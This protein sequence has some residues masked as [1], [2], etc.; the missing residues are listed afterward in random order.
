[1]TTHLIYIPINMPKFNQWAGARQ[2]CLVRRG[3]F[4]EGFAL[5]ILLSSLFGKSVLQPFRLF[6][7]DRRASASLYAY[8]SMSAADLH[9]RSKEVG[10]PDGLDILNGEIR[11]KVMPINFESGKRLGFDVRLRPVRRVKKEVLNTQ[12]GKMY[13]QGAE[14]DAF[15]L[16]AIHRFPEGWTEKSKEDGQS[17]RGQRAEC[18]IAW[19]ERVL[20][21]A[22]KVEQEECCLRSFK[23][24]RVVRGNGLGPEG[25]DI[26]MQG[27]IIV[28]DAVA[29]LS[30]L[31]KGV[32][33]HRA[34]GYGMLL[35]RPP[36]VSAA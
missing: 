17:L 12:S 31:R 16:E 22:A 20:A 5:H 15:I 1:M 9:S 32:G 19:L 30:L 14:V 8:A 11:S 6:F 27:N 29:F 24:R 2:R 35:L 3:I 28:E 33:R 18:Y 7:S 13:R 23:R 26:T 25:P 10:P 36:N 34:Y 4:D 21:G